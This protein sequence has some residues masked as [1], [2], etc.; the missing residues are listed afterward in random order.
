M[1]SKRS[2]VVA[3]A[4][5]NLFLLVALIF[6]SYS[7]P[8]ALA[9]RTGSSGNFLA[10]TAKADTD[11]DALFLIDLGDRRLHCF[12]PTRDRSGNIEPKGSR[13]LEQDFG[14]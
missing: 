10:I 5:V 7:L 12:L 6:G 9:Q 4:G 14:R 13:D 3:L 2:I 1:V 8:K 11:L